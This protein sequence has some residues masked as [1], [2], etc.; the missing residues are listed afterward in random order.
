MARTKQTARRTTGGIRG[1]H[2]KLT[3]KLAKRAQ[4]GGKSIT[5][6]DQTISIDGPGGKS[7]AVAPRKRRARSGS[8]FDCYIDCYIDKI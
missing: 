3:K 4:R 8:M 7:V 1:Y 6:G 5:I 2:N